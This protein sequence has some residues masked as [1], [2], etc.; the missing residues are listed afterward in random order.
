MSWYTT[1]EAVAIL[2]SFTR[3]PRIRHAKSAEWCSYFTGKRVTT[4]GLLWF[5]TCTQ[6]GQAPWHVLGALFGDPNAVG[7][8]SHWDTSEE[9]ATIRAKLA[10]TGGLTARRAVRRQREVDGA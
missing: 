10:A 7:W 8:K 2:D 6:L 1:P 9:W 5:D 3:R 4:L